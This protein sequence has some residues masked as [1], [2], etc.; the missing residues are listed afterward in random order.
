MNQMCLMTLPLRVKEL[1]GNK[2]YTFLITLDTDIGE[3]MMMHV[4]WEADPLWTSMWSKVKTI[5]PWASKED[6]PQVT[7]GRIRVKAG[8]TQ[9]RYSSTHV[10]RE[11][12]HGIKQN[13]KR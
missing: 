7:I 5:I 8:E 1:S 3:L 11:A 2:T 10:Y 6:G 4:A 9:Q 13:L 12:R